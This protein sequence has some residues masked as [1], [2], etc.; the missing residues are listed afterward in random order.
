MHRRNE[1]VRGADQD[2]AVT[3]AGHGARLP[4]R[5]RVRDCAGRH[6]HERAHNLNREDRDVSREEAVL[7]RS[8][9]WHCEGLWALKTGDLDAE[10]LV[11]RGDR[12]RR[13]GGDVSPDDRQF[14]MVREGSERPELVVALNW[15]EEL[16]RRGTGGAVPAA[17]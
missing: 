4:A 14:V 7:V 16:R 2:T 1:P 17:R 9:S 6:D 15:V 5:S 12:G 10:R 3:R 13:G 11:V 8:R